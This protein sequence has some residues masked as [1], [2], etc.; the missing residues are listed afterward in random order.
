MKRL[1]EVC[2]VKLALGCRMP[3]LEKHHQRTEGQVKDR[4]YVRAQRVHKHGERE[5]STHSGVPVCRVR[6]I[7]ACARQNEEA[8]HIA[9][10]SWAAAAAAAAA[11]VAAAAAAAPRI[12]DLPSFREV[13]V[14]L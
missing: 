7:M 12:N 2:F 1:A 6:S 8:L 11:A 3:S 4:Q 5:R 10:G 13:F 14:L 9:S